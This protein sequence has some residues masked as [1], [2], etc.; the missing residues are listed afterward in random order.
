MELDNNDPVLCRNGGTV[1]KHVC[2]F[3]D[4]PYRNSSDRGSSAG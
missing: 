1:R 3:T 2:L 4:T